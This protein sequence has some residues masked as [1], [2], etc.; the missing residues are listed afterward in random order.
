MIQVRLLQVESAETEAVQARVERVLESLEFHAQKCDVLVLPELWH[1]GAFNLAAV[2]S[3][4][5]TL[6]DECFQT[7][8]TIAAKTQT[9]IHAGSFAIKSES[10]KASNTSLLYGPS[11]HIAAQYRK[12]HLFGFADGERTVIDASSDQV[13][14]DSPLGITALT[15]CYDLR[16]PEQ[17][18]DLLDLGAE[19]FLTCAGWPTPRISHWEVL[20]RARAI[21]NQAWVVACNGRGTHAGV[22]LGGNSMVISPKG[23]VIAQASA[24]DEYIDATVDVSLVNEWR[25][26]FPVIADRIR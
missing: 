10:G 17:Y 20:N 6:D 3:H 22:T 16:F 14:I 15:T 19:T 26:S 8:S 11:G 13:L 1:I 18:R 24:D 12:Q 4:A 21:E 5:L 7:M 23:D 25:T 2:K 9:W